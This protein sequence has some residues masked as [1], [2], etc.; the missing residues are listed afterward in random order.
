MYN[1]SLKKEFINIV[2]A[3][4]SNKN[5]EDVAR[6]YFTTASVYEESIGKDLANF[7][8]AEIIGLY[9]YVCTSSLEVIMQMNSLFNRYTYYCKS[10]GFI[11]DGMNHFEEIS[12]DTMKLCITDR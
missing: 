10:I 7:S 5:I 6:R 2:A 1:D 3:Q 9:K 12:Y 11:D 8:M 4:C